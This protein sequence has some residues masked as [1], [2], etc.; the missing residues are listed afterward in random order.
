MLGYSVVDELWEL[1]SCFEY[2]MCFNSTLGARSGKEMGSVMAMHL[3]PK[4]SEAR[5]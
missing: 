5:L 4:M 1:I 2:V 3:L